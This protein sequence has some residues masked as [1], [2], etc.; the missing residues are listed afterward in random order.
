MIA[1]VQSSSWKIVMTCKTRKL[2]RSCK[3]Q[4]SSRTFWAKLDQ[5]QEWINKIMVHRKNSNR[6]RLLQT[7]HTWTRSFKKSLRHS[8]TRERLF[9]LPLPICPLTTLRS[10]FKSYYV[11][12]SCIWPSTWLRCSTN[13][14]WRRSQFN[15]QRE[16]RNTSKEILQ[17]D[18]LK[19]MSKM[20]G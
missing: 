14:H 4:E 9:M 17:S 1:T 3:W 2:W 20:R 10:A 12:K 11:H 7:I 19:S 18:C 5:N 16:Q 8:F 6:S 13:Q 15:W